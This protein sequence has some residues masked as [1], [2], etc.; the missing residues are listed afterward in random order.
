MKFENLVPG[1][2]FIYKESAG[3]DD[4]VR[5]IMKLDTNPEVD[6]LDFVNLKSNDKTHHP[7]TA[8]A[9][10]SGCL[11]RIPGSTEVVRLG[12]V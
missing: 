6:R 4:K 3:L 1:D 10:C 12:K 8:V 11:L 2:K 5:I 9:L 7:F